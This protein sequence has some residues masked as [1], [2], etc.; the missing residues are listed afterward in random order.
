MSKNSKKKRNKKYN[1]RKASPTVAS[2]QLRMNKLGVWFTCDNEHARVISM[3][4]KT[5]FDPASKTARLLSDYPH[6]WHYTMFVLAKKQDGT[7]YITTGE[8]LLPDEKGIPL[9]ARRLNQADLA[10]SLDSA[11]KAFL[12][13]VNTLHIVNTGWVAFPYP[14]EISEELIYDITADMGAWDYLSR[15]EKQQ[16]E[17]QKAK[18]EEQALLNKVNNTVS[19]KLRIKE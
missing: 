4:S 15:W 14:Q 13:S 17:A 2:Q 3:R 19:Q 9:S 8:P 16:K 6:F 11:H 1:P 18:D 12:K 7:R 10:N 5:V